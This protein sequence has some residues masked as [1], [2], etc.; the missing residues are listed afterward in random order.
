M[1]AISNTPRPGYAYDSTDD[2]WYPI[3]TGPHTHD[4]APSG[5]VISPTV[6]DAKGDII[7]A[8]AADTVAKLAV[9]SNNQV[10]TADSSTATGLKW[11]TPSAGGLTLIS[12]TA[13]TG[14]SVTLSSIPTT[15]KNLKLI[16]KSYYGSGVSFLSLRLNGDS[17]GNVYYFDAKSLDNGTGDYVPAGDSYLPIIY[18]SSSTASF[19]SFAQVEIPQYTDTTGGQFVTAFGYGGN[20]RAGWSSRAVYNNRSAAITS[21]TIFQ[22]GGASMSGGSVTL[23]GEA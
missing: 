12:T 2:V 9:G 23:Y 13:L 7:A 1:P 10:L 4:Y 19:L 16:I 11:A 8:T 21:I 17:G 6:V 5:G 22:T 3:G 15:Y 18:A 14:S 20:S